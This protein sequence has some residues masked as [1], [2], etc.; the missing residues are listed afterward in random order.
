[1]QNVI[2][3]SE[4]FPG[5]SV[6]LK[7]SMCDSWRSRPTPT[8]TFSELCAHVCVY[9]YAQARVRMHTYTMLKYKAI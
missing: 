6:S 3:N 1:M 2:G 7:T 8:L 4:Q 5:V 9:I